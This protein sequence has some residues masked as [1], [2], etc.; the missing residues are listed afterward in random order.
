MIYLSRFAVINVEDVEYM[1]HVDVLE[2]RLKSIDRLLTEQY[3]QMLG[4]DK[5]KDKSQ[6]QDANKK[7]KS[8][9]V[10]EKLKLGEKKG[11]T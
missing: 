3:R 6:L 8:L 7:T 10:F 5:P 4:I 2:K 1:D 9:A 11:S